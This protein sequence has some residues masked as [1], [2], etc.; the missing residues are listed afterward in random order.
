MHICVNSLAEMSSFTKFKYNWVAI[1]I[2]V[3]IYSCNYYVYGRI[4]EL[5]LPLANIDSTIF[6]L[7]TCGLQIH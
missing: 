3:E 1:E 4:F 5:T 6:L 7:L 2:F